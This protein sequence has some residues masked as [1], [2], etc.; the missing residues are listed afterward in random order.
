[1]PQENGSRTLADAGTQPAARHPRLA[2]SRTLW[3]SVCV[4]A[5]CLG[6]RLGAQGPEIRYLYDDVGRLVAVIDQAGDAAV[7]TYD[8]VGNVVAISHQN[9][10][11]VKILNFYPQSGLPGATV[12][13]QGLGFSTTAGQNTVLFNGTAAAVASATQTR[14]A[15]IVPAGATTGLMS[16]TTPGG[17]ASSASAF[18]VSQDTAPP[19]ITGF[20]PQ[21]GRPGASIVVSGSQFHPQAALNRPRFNVRFAHAHTVTATS[22]A[23]AVPTGATSGPIFV[24]TPFGEARSP[25]D[26]FVPPGTYLETD[27]GLTGRLTPGQNASVSLPIANKIGLLVFDGLTGPRVTLRVTGVTVTSAFVSISR[28][29]GQTLIAPFHVWAGGTRYVETPLPADPGTYTVL[30]DPASSY[31]GGMTLL[32]GSPTDLTPPIVPG[33]SPVTVNL[34]VLGQNAVLPFAG[35][36]GQRVSLRISGVTIPASYVSI[37]RPDSLVL[38]PPDGVT[39]AGH[40]IEPLTLPST[41]GYTILLDPSEAYLGN[42]T[43]TLY[44]VPAD[45]MGA[46]V[47]G[48]SP[49]GVSLGTP[50]QNA[51]FAFAGTAGQR[52]S[53]RITGSSI[54]QSHISIRKPD[55]AALVSPTWTTGTSSFVDMVTLPTTGT[56]TVVVDPYLANTG[57]MTLTLYDVPPDF[58][59]TIVPG[60]ASTAVTIGTPGQNAQISFTGGAGQRVSLRTTSS[61]ISQRY[62]SIQKPDGTGLVSPTF[63]TGSSSFVDTVPLPAAGSYT[64]VVN[65]YLANTGSLTLSLYDVPT[66]ASGT[67]TIGGAG[68][69]VAMGTPGQN[70]VLSFAGSSGQQITVRVTGNTAG[71]TAVSLVN[72]SGGTVTSSSGSGTF[73]LSS[74]T[75]AATGTYQIRV[76][77]NDINTGT[78]TISVTTP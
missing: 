16:V 58:T 15:V 4:A 18:V 43:L 29:G 9:A 23:T 25:G 32:L 55:G 70:G 69:P 49:V 51:H 65:P 72:P 64:I 28:P 57:S 42:A 13:I 63:Q 77:P 54:S 27:I 61:T 35:T 75:L 17:A 47:P 19:T 68:A 59:G 7:Y 39:V 2:W 40:F 36:N 44:D 24:A 33:G 76:N 10:S 62:V 53:L 71:F 30:I 52:V 34:A 41:G 5:L 1:M 46:I 66:D 50:G 78:V 20:S 14:L 6:A 37:M 12:V 48:G 73:N 60:G 21:I 74:Q 38:L 26:F 11:T 67:L 3:R 45:V 31:T 8:A 22:F 56:Y